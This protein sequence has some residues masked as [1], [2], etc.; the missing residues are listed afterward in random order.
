MRMESP[1][2]QRLRRSPPDVV[3]TPID[4]TSAGGN[5]GP[6]EPPGP[7]C[8]GHG[9]S[10]EAQSKEPEDIER[11]AK[12]SAD[13][14]EGL[15]DG[16]DCRV[17]IPLSRPSGHLY[18][19]DP[20]SGCEHRGE[21]KCDQ[22]RV[23]PGATAPFKPKADRDEPESGEYGCR[24]DEAV[25]PSPCGR[26]PGDGCRGSLH[27]VCHEGWRLVERWRQE[28]DCGSHEHDCRGSDEY[29]ASQAVSDT[30]WLRRFHV[31]FP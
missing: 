8:L 6:S 11:H 22:T 24:E 17:G 31:N 1:L 15:P 21:D 18:A 7:L 26:V 19:D 2:N 5:K 16:K 3:Y 20:I 30:V 29:R 23:G 25:G 13:E 9:D 10:I 28:P 4:V 12:A 27:V 14:F